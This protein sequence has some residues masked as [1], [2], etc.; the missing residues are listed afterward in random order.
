MLLIYPDLAATPVSATFYTIGHSTHTIESFVSL[1]QV[2]GVNYLVD[3][4]TVPKS[5]TNPQF[6][7]DLMPETLGAYQ[8]GYEHVAELGGLRGR[9]PLV[10]SPNT[11]WQNLSFRNYA[12]YAM[13]PA[14]ASGLQHLRDIGHR[15]TSAIMCAEAVWWRCHR[16]IIADYLLA[17]REHVLHIMPEGSQAEATLTPSARPEG[18]H[19]VYSAAE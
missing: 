18:S 10:A 16:R 5:R 11:Y 6:N 9:Q 15:H 19:L 13:S 3:V 4:R 1:L 14:F 7:K 12:D 2:A 17:A 8:I